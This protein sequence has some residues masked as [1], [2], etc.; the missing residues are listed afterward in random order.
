MAH[1]RTVY[2]R[3]ES[4]RLFGPTPDLVAQLRSVKGELPSTRPTGTV[5]ANPHARQAST[6]AWLP[7]EPACPPCV[8]QALNRGNA[9]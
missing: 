3:R 9:P 4:D 5:A 7:S 6:H 8:P 2:F 1:C